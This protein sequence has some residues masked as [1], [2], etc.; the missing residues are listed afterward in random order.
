M[1][2][3]TKPL[4]N[5]E[6]V[7]AKAA[8]KQYSLADGD[9]LYLRIATS[10]T[11][12][13]LFNYYRPHTKKRANLSF[14]NYPSVT[15]A[16]ARLM[17]SNARSLLAKEIDPQTSKAQAEREN[18]NKVLATFEFTAAAWLEVK[19]NRVS[20]DHAKDI[21][22]SLELHVFPSLGETTNIICHSTSCH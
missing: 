4:S 18:K 7:A 10:G 1:P 5:I 15:L 12:T 3:I 11:K 20:S 22:R 14:G 21:W 17:R 2:K 9:G 19:K 8:E 6:L 13:W 16:E